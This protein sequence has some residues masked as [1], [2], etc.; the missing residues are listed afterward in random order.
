MPQPDQ[1]T[2]GEQRVRGRVRVAPSYLLQG[3]TIEGKSIGEDLVGIT[4][5]RDDGVE[6]MLPWT[7]VGYLIR[8]PKAV[9]DEPF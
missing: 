8:N 4:V 6:M 3:G 9:A 5:R 7:S 2:A 1:P